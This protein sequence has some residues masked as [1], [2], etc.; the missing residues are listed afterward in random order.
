VG[1]CISSQA[2]LG[3]GVTAR[4]STGSQRETGSWDVF[5]LHVSMYG[6]AIQADIDSRNQNLP[7]VAVRGTG[8]G[9]E[10]AGVEIRANRR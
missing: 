5:C 8:R 1:R 9:S 4:P 2:V 10:G 6:Q 7:G 3:R